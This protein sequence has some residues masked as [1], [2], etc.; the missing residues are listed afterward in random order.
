[1]IHYTR[2][3]K[4]YDFRGY[5]VFAI[6]RLCY[7]SN[8][9]CDGLSSA[10]TRMETGLRTWLHQNNFVMN[11]EHWIENKVQLVF[12]G[13]LYQQ[14]FEILAKQRTSIKSNNVLNRQESDACTWVLPPRPTTH[15]SWNTSFWNV[16]F[17]MDNVLDLIGWLLSILTATGNGFVM[18]V[19][20]KNR[21]LYSSAN[22]FV[23]SLAVADFWVGV[24]VL[25]SSYFCY[26]SMACN[27]RV[28]MAFFWF[29]LHSSVTNLC[30]LTWGRYI[31]IVHPL[32]YNTSMTERRPGMV[33]LTAWLISFPTSLSL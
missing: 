27:S 22:W 31:A 16:S 24:A 19:V 10:L 2:G 1:M 18:F 15:Q 9:I 3:K 5:Y 14:M 11:H 4:G 26:K 25:P 13:Q 30:S 20:A 23:L 8:T 17:K 28:S 33:I 32:V 21:R 7:Y 29:F 6:Q 12:T